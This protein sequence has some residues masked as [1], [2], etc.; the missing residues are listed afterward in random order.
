MER[1]GGGNLRWRACRR[2]NHAFTLIELVVVV[3]IIAIIAAIAIPKMSRGS[4]G[5]ADA[6]L[7]QDLSTIRSALELY[8]T[9]HGGT[10]PSATDAPT[11]LN[12]LTEYTDASGA[13]QATKDTAH[14]YGPYIKS[15]PSLPVGTN[16]G[17]NTVTISGPAGT[18]AFGW[19]YDGTTVW[20]NDPSTDTDIKTTPYNTY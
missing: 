1:N 3:V 5:A 10:Y 15:I 8:Q 12:Q 6:A 7:S 9:E 17:L 18:G 4:A 14:I 16:K 11:F 13:A 19:Y 2:P 20:A